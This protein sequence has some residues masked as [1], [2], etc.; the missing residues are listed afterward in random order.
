MKLFL[1]IVGLLAFFP[2][3]FLPLLMWITRQT[4]FRCSW[5]GHWVD[6]SDMCGKDSEF[7]PPLHLACCNACA[8]QEV[9]AIDECRRHEALEA[10]RARQE[11]QED[12]ITRLGLSY[13]ESIGLEPDDYR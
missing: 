6:I 7:P 12:A 4:Q 1:F 11:A 3:V 10:E 13:E 9:A 2:C 8:D 5:C